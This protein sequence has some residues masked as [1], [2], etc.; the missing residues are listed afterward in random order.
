LSE[1]QEHEFEGAFCVN[2]G[3]DEAS[4]F[5]NEP[6]EGFEE[7]IASASHVSSADNKESE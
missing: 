1:E 4:S 3:V 7:S 2:C 6:C 5:A